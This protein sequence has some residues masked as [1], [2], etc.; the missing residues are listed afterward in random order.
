MSDQSAAGSRHAMPRVMKYI[1]A[2]EGAYNVSLNFWLNFRVGDGTDP[3]VIVFCWGAGSAFDAIPLG[4]QPRGV[5]VDFDEDEPLGEA[6]YYAALFV[7]MI[8]SKAV[9]PIGPRPSL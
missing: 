7:E 4:L 5:E 2:L 1:Q 3:V 8:L 6:I 9:E